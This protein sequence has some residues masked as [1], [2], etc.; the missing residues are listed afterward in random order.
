MNR[1]GRLVLILAMAGALAFLYGVS[2]IWSDYMWFAS[3]GYRRV[4]W[5]LFLTRFAVGMA[6]FLLFLPFFWLNSWF[7]RR[8]LPRVR[9]AGEQS[10]IIELTQGPLLRLFNSRAGT[11]VL[12]LISA[13]ISLLLA[14]PV[15]SRW[16]IVQKLVYATSFGRRDPIFGLDAGFYIFKLPFY[17]LLQSTL[18]AAFTI[19][20]VLAALIYLLL[21]SGEFFGGGWRRF[22][23]VKLHLAVLVAGLLIIKAWDYRLRAYQLLLSH[24][25]AFWGAGYT[26]VHARIPALNILAVLALLAAVL[27]FFGVIRGRLRPIFWGIG[28]LVAA[29]LLLGIAYPALVQQFQVVPNE[30]SREQQYLQYAITST[31]YAYGLDRVRVLNSGLES[32][33]DGQAGVGEAVLEKYRSTLTNLRLWDFRP[34]GQVYNQLQ[35]LRPY[36]RFSDVDIDRYRIGGD[37]RQVMLSV[38]ELSQESLA[39]RAQ[40]WVNRRLQYTHGFGVVVSPV[41]ETTPEGLPRFLVQNI[42]PKAQAP[43]LAVKQPRIYFGE[44][45]TNWVVVNT[46]AKEFDYPS[47]DKNVYTSYSGR[48]GVRLSNP[49]RRLLYAFRFQDMRLLLSDDI[50]PESRILYNR[51]VGDARRLA[52]Y[53]EYDGDPYPVITNGRIYWIWD[54]YTVT[55]H[56][57]YSEMHSGRNYIRNSVKVVVDAYQGDIAFYVSDP[58]DPLIRTYGKIFPGLYRP[59]SRMPEGL[60]SHLRYPV[61][62][63]RTQATVYA[64]YHI[65]DPRVFY[66]REDEW[67]IPFEKYSSSSQ[68][69][70][71]YYAVMQLPGEAQEEFVLVLPLTPVKRQNL[72]A[73]MAARCD[74]ENYGELAVDVFPKDVHAYGPMQVEASID[75]NAEISQALTLWD[76]RGSE[77]IR[78]NLIT[79]PLA[80]KLL[81]VK[82]LFLQARESSLPELTRV[83]LFY[84]GRIV[85]ESSLDRALERLFGAGEIPPAAE[86]QQPQEAEG[87]AGLTDLAQRANQL[88]NEAMERQR[89]GD[90]AGYG[91]AVEELGRVLKQMVGR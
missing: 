62:L 5:T 67:A 26:D 39:E 56:Y 87:Q 73:W 20:L 29:S 33:A 36:Y 31:R 89:S 53:L 28:A 90:W 32:T 65:G 80:G 2:G 78:G 17:E 19:A 81:Y 6:A 8:C 27:V 15:G 48:G 45:T 49:L 11:A 74:G 9:L 84:D 57:P 58:S 52:P 23:P 3:L 21:A 69:M 54:A 46:K 43:E 18:A 16:E 14:V 22:S 34:I 91:R 76:Q 37:S 68:Q 85:M 4:F 64:L 70:E 77:V 38:R 10:R 24:H 47:G 51:T 86:V 61:D 12:L 41:N 82:P 79:V 75:Q 71:P 72:V 42:P 59:L 44:L 66:N 25:G 30:F 7:A 40:T 13:L 88:Y 35:Q 50:T 1:R 60:R 55:D 63:F 83:I